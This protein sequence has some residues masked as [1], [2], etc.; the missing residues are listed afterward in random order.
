[1]FIPEIKKYT[2]KTIDQIAFCEIFNDI[3]LDYSYIIFRNETIPIV[4]RYSLKK[5]KSVFK[6]ELPKYYVQQKES[7]LPPPKY[8]MEYIRRI[9]NGDI[10]VEWESLILFAINNKNPLA[11]LNTEDKINKLLLPSLQ[12]A[13]KTIGNINFKL[14]SMPKSFEKAKIVPDNDMCISVRIEDKNNSQSDLIIIYPYITL[15][16]L[17]SLLE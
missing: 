4:V 10:K 11:K 5:T 1:M 2:V 14:K 7:K 17:L 16:P 12:N 15:E 8:L 13:W 3:K 6:K 9:S